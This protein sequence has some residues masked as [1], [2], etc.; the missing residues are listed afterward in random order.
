MSLGG[1]TSTSW[2]TLKITL[3]TRPHLTHLSPSSSPRTGESCHARLSDGSR[4][5]IGVGLLCTLA[6]ISYGV[7]QLI[8][9]VTHGA[10]DH[11][12]WRYR[13]YWYSES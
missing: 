10:V 13:I 5:T 9:A 8:M 1:F 2:L 4:T 12:D 6:S 11:Y 3:P 7:V